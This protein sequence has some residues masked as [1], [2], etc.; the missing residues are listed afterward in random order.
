[1][2]RPITAVLAGLAAF[3]LV[4]A[5]AATLGGL[6]VG[7]LGADSDDV[8]AC[9][10]PGGIDVT[11]TTG[12]YD[13]AEDLFPVAEV[14][15]SAPDAESCDGQLATIVLLDDEPGEGTALATVEAT[16][17]G[18]TATASLTTT[19]DAAAVEGIAV[20]VVGS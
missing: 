10:D 20:S 14:E 3:S 4:A 17:S 6:T 19:V 15:L 13:A 5:T 7:G 8:A 2:N 12:T 16:F 9:S 18:Q 11:F 1:V